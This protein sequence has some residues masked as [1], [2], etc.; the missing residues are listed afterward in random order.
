MSLIPIFR[1]NKPRRSHHFYD[2]FTMDIWNPFDDFNM[3]HRH[4]PSFHHHNITKFEWKETPEAH[5][6]RA[7][8]P[9]F[10]K[11]EVKVDVEEGQVLK[12]SG[13]KEVEKEEKHE[14]WEYF[15]HSEGKFLR[16][17]TLPEN[18]KHD[19]VRCS[20]ENGV[21]TVTVPKRGC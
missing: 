11:E 9:G 8:L 21:L 7:E 2:P 12:I 20:W 14:N 10:K 18:V 1:T 6:L 3:D 15:E 5:V 17:F 19:H 13:K 4:I 16:A